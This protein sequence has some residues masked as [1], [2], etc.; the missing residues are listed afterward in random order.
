[1]SPNHEVLIGRDGIHARRRLRGR[2]VGIRKESPH[3]VAN[4]VRFVR[5]HRAINAVRMHIRAVIM[6][7]DLEPIADIGEAVPRLVRCVLRNEDRE[8]YATLPD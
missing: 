5:T 8:L 4:R 2:A 1:M 3:H 6:Q 7:R